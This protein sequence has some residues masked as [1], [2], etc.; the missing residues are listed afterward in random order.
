MSEQHT[1]PSAYQTVQGADGEQQPLLYWLGSKNLLYE[2]YHTDGGP[3]GRSSFISCLGKEFKPLPLRSCLCAHCSAGKDALAQLCAFCSSSEVAAVCLDANK[4]SEFCSAAQAPG[5]YL[6]AENRR[7]VFQSVMH[8]SSSSPLSCRHLLPLQVYDMLLAPLSL[9]R[10]EQG[11]ALQAKAAELQAAVAAYSEHLERWGYQSARHVQHDAA[12]T[13]CK[14]V[15][16]CDFKEKVKTY[17]SPRLLQSDWFNKSMGVM[18]Y[19]SVVFVYTA[20]SGRV[21]RYYDF[22]SQNDTEQDTYWVQ[23]A[24]ALLVQE[25]AADFPEVF[26]SVQGWSDNGPH[27]HNSIFLLR[28]LALL[29]DAFQ[30]D[31]IEWN[32]FEPG[33]AKN[34]CDQHFSALGGAF[35]RHLRS[36][37]VINGAD[38]VK[39]IA[40]QLANTV[41]EY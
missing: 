34:E 37:K 22:I 17:Q 28:I 13:K 12:A 4:R 19:F 3:L 41:V 29:R 39:A 25:V 7:D 14:V 20:E 26:E 27:F 31:S 21:Y 40:S 23:C 15:M 5:K 24:I 9:V 18:S 10:G 8:D 33:E 1:R 6:Q 30:L 38:D 16:V 35:C 36:N 2:L 11:N 32:F